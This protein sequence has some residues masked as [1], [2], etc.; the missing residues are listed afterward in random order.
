MHAGKWD[1]KNLQGSELRGK[2]LGILGLGRIG[3]EVAKRAKGFG[4]EIIGSDPFVSVAVARENGIKLV[5]LDD[6]LDPDRYIRERGVEAY[7]KAVRGAQRQA[8]YLI[9]RAR[10]MFPESIIIA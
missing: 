3:Q 5:T 4:L 10:K 1:K 2:T 9:E 8:D 6:G 7:M